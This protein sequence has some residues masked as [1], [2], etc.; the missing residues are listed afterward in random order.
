MKKLALTLVI[1][2]ALAQYPLWYGKGSWL[3]V[4]EIDQQITAQRQ[5]N[6]KLQ[7]RNTVLEAE[8]NNLKQGLDAIEELARNELGMIRKDEVFFQILENNEEMTHK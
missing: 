3:N 4:F 8:V 1:L 6:Q 5:I 2:I 7:N